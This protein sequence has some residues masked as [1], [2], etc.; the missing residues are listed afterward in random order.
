MGNRR[1][2]KSSEVCMVIEG[3]GGVVLTG[4]SQFWSY[5][6]ENSH[7][8]EPTRTNRPAYHGRL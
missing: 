8:P 6:D 5:Q 3:F 4:G 2:W 7:S 1:Y